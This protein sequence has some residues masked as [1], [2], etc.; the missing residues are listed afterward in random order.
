MVTDLLARIIDAE[1]STNDLTLTMADWAAINRHAVAEGWIAPEQGTRND[2]II[3]LA[4]TQDGVT[5]VLMAVALSLLPP[6]HR[7][8]F[9]GPH[10]LMDPEGPVT[11]WACEG[12]H[13]DLIPGTSVESQWSER[14]E[15]AILLAVVK[16]RSGDPK[17]F[18]HAP[19][20]DDTT[21]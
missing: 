1:R 16:L 10:H 2:T 4:T 13:E 8:A 3:T 14:P 7:V 6:N 9:A 15:V 12:Y 21:T 20:M 5:E 17:V 19:V 11:L 18:N